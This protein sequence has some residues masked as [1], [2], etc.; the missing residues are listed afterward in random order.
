MKRVFCIALIALGLLAFTGCAPC[1][2]RVCKVRY[3]ADGEQLL[4]DAWGEI[5]EVQDELLD[6]S[7]VEITLRDGGIPDEFFDD[8]IISVEIIS[9]PV[10]EIPKETVVA[11]LDI[12]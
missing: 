2:K 4:F 8:R 7:V 12:D 9:V 11:P 3:N 10:E 6:G 1:Y 5:W